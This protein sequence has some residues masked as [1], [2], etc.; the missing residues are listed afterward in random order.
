MRFSAKKGRTPKTICTFWVIHFLS[1]ALMT[2]TSIRSNKDQSTKFVPLSYDLLP[3][4]YRCDYV[5]E[6]DNGNTAEIRKN[7]VWT[8]GGGSRAYGNVHSEKTEEGLVICCP[9]GASE[10]Y[11]PAGEKVPWTSICAPKLVHLPFASN[12]TQF[13]TVWIAPMLPSLI[14]LSVHVVVVVCANVSYLIP[15]PI[16]QLVH[17]A[18]NGETYKQG[19]LKS[20]AFRRICL[21]FLIMN[22]RGWVLFIFL[23]KFQDTAINLLGWALDQNISCWYQPYLRARQ[24]STHCY[25]KAYDFSDHFVLFFGHILPIVAFEAL[26]IIYGTLSSN[27]SGGGPSIASV[28]SQIRKCAVI[29]FALYMHL[30]TFMNAYKTAA[31]FHTPS[32]VLLGYALSLTIQLPLG[33]I[34]LYK[35]ES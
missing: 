17:G 11:A 10:R 2:V 6:T 23:N 33:Y 9:T 13:W 20:P 35:F 30:I 16:L 32:E 29:I 22:F 3:D 19:F 31:F 1:C 34:I 8:D 15:R 28:F 14:E 21:Y 5:G 18:D 24:S 27:R 4:R 26:H 12:L 25:G 7:I